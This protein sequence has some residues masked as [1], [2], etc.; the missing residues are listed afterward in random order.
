ILAID[1][2]FMSPRKVSNPSHDE[3]PFATIM[4][5]D[6]RRE[7]LFNNIH[8]HRRKEITVR[9]YI[10]SVPVTAYSRPFFGIA[11]PR[12]DVFITDWPIYTMSIF[13]VCFKIQVTESVTLATPCKRTSAYMIATVP[14][15]SFHLNI[16]AFFLIH[17]KIEI[18]FIQRIIPAEY[19]IIFDH[20]LC[21][22]AAMREVPRVFGCRSIVLHM[23]HIATSLQH[24]GFKPFLGQ[25]FRSPASAN[26]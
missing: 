9:Q 1:P 4:R 10:K 25:L 22:T 3:M 7:V 26:P 15:E 19:R 6:A 18:P 8:F 23:L 5:F 12:S 20:L 21:P 11:I 14:V 17:P 24:N 16:R 13:E 2:A